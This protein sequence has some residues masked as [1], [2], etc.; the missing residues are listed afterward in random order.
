MSSALVLA[1]NIYIPIR[2]FLEGYVINLADNQDISQI[3][4]N[5]YVGNVSTATNRELL[6]E[7]GITHIINILS[8]KFEPY[9]GDFEYLHVSAYDMPDQ[10]LTYN[11]PLTNLFIRN[12]LK[13]GGKVY[14]HCM[15]GVSRSVTI[16][17]AYLMTQTNKSINTILEDVRLTRPIANPNPGFIT[18]LTS[19]RS[20]TRKFRESM[21]DIDPLL[22]SDVH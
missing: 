22:I 4:P 9:P 19:F 7:T 10:D 20:N 13:H 5:L 3:T 8:H 15:M 2:L 14:I 6:K 11:F 1:K 18:Q 21:L 12:A 17:L 16:L